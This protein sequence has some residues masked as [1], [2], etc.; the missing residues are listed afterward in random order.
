MSIYKPKASPFYHYDFQVSGSRFCGSTGCTSRREAE[1]IERAEKEEARALLKRGSANT[2]DLT[3]SEAALRYWE[4]VG[5]YHACASETFVNL[6]RIEDHFG[7]DKRLS[8][9]HDDEVTK[10]VA[11]RRGHR[12]WGR[13]N[14]AL[15]SAATINR[16]T[17]EVL[18]K[19]FTR[20]KK[21]WGT[22]FDDEPDW[23]GHMLPEAEEHVRELR[24]DEACKLTLATRHDYAPFPS[25]VRLACVCRSAC[26]NG[27]KLIGALASSP[28]EGRGV[29]A[30]PRRLQLR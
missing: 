29:A 3:I 14:S 20:A 7:K 4:E 19:L 23:R 21:K 17:T 26:S 28:S 2:A 30:S 13:K 22:R 24:D 25:R 18:Q 12:R 1:G 8:E 6:E 27:R 9:I 10:L 16:S 15:I 11:W 5:Q